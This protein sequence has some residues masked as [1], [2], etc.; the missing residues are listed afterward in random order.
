MKYRVS[1]R[2]T[3]GYSKPV[4][5]SVGL[6]HLIPRDLPWQR[7]LSSDVVV[8]PEPGDISRDT[9]YFGN[10][11][12]YFHVTDPHS[13]LVIQSTSDVIAE[14][15]VYDSAALAAPWED[16]RPLLNP[17]ASGAWRA[18]EYALESARAGHVDE[19]TAYAAAS[20]IP[21][22]P[23]GEAVTDLMHRIYADFAYDSKATTVTSTVADVMTARAG[24]LSGLRPPRAR[25]PARARHRRPL[26]ERLPCDPAPAGQR[27]RVR[28]GCL[29][30]LGGGMDAGIRRVARFRP[31]EQPVGERPL[32]HRGLGS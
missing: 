19:A 26:R 6:F 15:P 9:D 17:S 31:D 14:V 30:R 23:V 10:S 2:T 18:T 22:R 28:G 12:T 8:T 4:Q 20:L 3:Y 27:A 5:D 13:T 7:V 16:S 29:A 32:H 1:H 21:G 11:S 24:R 25:V